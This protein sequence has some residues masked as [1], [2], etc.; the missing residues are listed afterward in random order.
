MQSLPLVAYLGGAILS[1]VIFGLLGFALGLRSERRRAVNA[2]AFCLTMSRMDILSLVGRRI[3][4]LVAAARSRTGASP[5]AKRLL[6]DSALMSDSQAAELDLLSRHWHAFK[7]RHVD[8]M[9][10]RLLD[11]ADPTVVPNTQGMG[12]STFA[13]HH[14]K[15]SS[16]PVSR[17][18]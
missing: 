3:Q 15:T 9:I 7:D 4:D 17:P 1:G 18:Q 14:P 10:R 16:T 12:Q 2:N 6:N 11:S 5:H 13:G 8:S